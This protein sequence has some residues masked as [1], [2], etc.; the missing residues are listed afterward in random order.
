MSGGVGSQFGLVLTGGGARGAYQVGVL[1]ALGRLYP[2]ARFPIITGVSAGAIN[3]VYLASHPWGLR[4]AAHDLSQLWRHLELDDVVE[5]NLGALSSNFLRWISKLGLGGAGAGPE[6]RSLL[7]TTPLRRLLERQLLRAEGADAAAS[8]LLHG[9]ERNLEAGRLRAIALSTVNYGTGQTVTWVQGGRAIEP[10]AAPDRV[11]RLGPLT[12]DHVLAS[13]SLPLLFPAVRLDDGWYGDGGIRL[14]APLSPALHL[15]A[16][17]LLAVSTRYARGAAELAPAG[18]IEYPS[19]ARIAGNLMNAIFL[20]VVDQDVDRLRRLDR[21]VRRLPDDARDGLRPVELLVLRPSEDLGRLSARYEPRLPE[22]FRFFARS[23]G[24]RQDQSPDFLSLLMFQPDYLRRLIELGER[25]TLA[26]E[27][28][29]RRFV[30]AA[31]TPARRPHPVSDTQRPASHHPARST[32]D[33]PAADPLTADPAR[34]AAVAATLE[35]RAEARVPVD[36]PRLRAYLPMLYVAWADGDLDVTEAAALCPSL[37]EECRRVVEPWVDPTR[38]PSPQELSHMLRAVRRGADLDA[39]SRRERLDLTGLGL[40]IAKADERVTPPER[41]ALERLEDALGIAG[42]EAARQLLA[43]RRPG[44][45]VAEPPPPFD[46]AALTAYL[47]HDWS[48]VRARMLV[49]LERDEFSWH[50]EP[51]RHTY[52]EQVLAWLQILADEGFGALATPEEHGGAGDVGAFITAFETLAFFDLSLLV[53]YGVQFGLWGGSVQNLGTARHHEEFLPGIGS[54]A[55]PG[56]YAMTEFSHGSN[57]ADLETVARFDV[58]QDEWVV[59]TPTRGSRKNYI[60]NVAAHATHATVFAQLEVPCAEAAEDAGDE[61]GTGGGEHGTSDAQGSHAWESHGVHAFI[62]PIR[63]DDGEPLPGV[64]IGDDGP[65]MGL[66]GVDNGWLALDGVRIPRTHL[67]DRFAR[68]DVDGAYHSPIASASKRFFTMLGTLVA[69]RVSV[70]LAAGSV[71]KTALAI[72]VRYAVQRR[73]FGPP[74]EAETAILDY[75]THQRRLLPRLARTYAL[76]FALHDLRRRFVASQRDPRDVEARREVE[77][78]AA[79]LKTL[80][81]WHTTDTVQTCRECCGGQGYL[82]ENRFA[83][84]KADSD[85]FTTFEGDNMVLLQL[86]GKSL[87]AGYKRQFS[88][89]NI[90]GLVRFVAAGATSSMLE[91]MSVRLGSAD[92]LRDREVASQALAW[93]AEHALAALARGLKARLDD[94][95]EPHDAI[96]AHQNELVHASIAHVERLVAERFAEAVDAAPTP[97]QRESLDLQ[98]SLYALSCIES[99]AAFFLEHG[100][101]D[102]GKS[103]AVRE[104]V[105]V[106]CA[107]IRPQARHLV[108]AFGIPA[109]LLAAPIAR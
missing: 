80:S 60:G 76:H 45:H 40:E 42:T 102:A 105:T 73:Q 94:G 32:A 38:P 17:R 33:V 53:K 88:E 72:A 90:V 109:K 30:D 31:E 89:M 104:H 99:D 6:V 56:C 39:L 84:L 10:W 20:D 15:G 71:A 97:E 23:F 98:W 83:A 78:L 91:K 41:A 22:G 92:R 103:Q 37:D 63:G 55:I 68:V 47:T 9:I 12:L 100:Y 75:P 11:A 35:Y 19:P 44:V 82:S 43:T 3:A 48:E 101:L 86:V 34:Q 79:G 50:L 2:S 69:G 5:S 57:V 24:S 7:D 36:D 14:A 107:E 58:A 81:T 67:L 74:G 51:A 96:L 52:R 93:R 62:V 95:V 66:N 65:K 54:L 28:E 49:L 8:G 29:I 59:S 108:D 25:D 87:L 16:D 1:R 4:R 21:L 64:E 70:A 85:V 46:V 61:G 106:L 27:A 77:T 13:S 26:R 18:P